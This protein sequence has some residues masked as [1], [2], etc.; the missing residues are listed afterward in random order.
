MACVRK[1]AG[2]WCVD[3]RDHTGRRHIEKRFKTRKEAEHRLRTIQQDIDQGSYEAPT[4]ARRFDELADAFEIG[5]IAVQLRATTAR[6]IARICGYT[7]SHISR[8]ASCA[9]LPAT[10]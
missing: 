6:T 3:Y 7:F 2:K 8:V 9:A 1:R 4:G 5:H 10:R